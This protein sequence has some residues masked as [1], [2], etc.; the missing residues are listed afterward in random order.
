MQARA[1]HERAAIDLEDTSRRIELEVRTD[2]SNFREAAEVLKSQE[3]VV[4]QGEE[5]LRLAAARAAAGSATQLDVL[6]AQTALTDARTTQV[7]AL[8]DYAVARARLVR[9]IG[10]GMIPQAAAAATNSK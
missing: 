1:L 10:E 2:Y 8:H 4:E 3:K 9:A 7:Q 5:A 6:S